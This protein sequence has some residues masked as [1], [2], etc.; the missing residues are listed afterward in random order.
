[1]T[2]SLDFSHA[3]V[4]GLIQGKDITFLT[5]ILS[6]K[7]GRPV[8]ITSEFH[9][10]LVF[11]DP[12]DLGIQ[13][14][15]FF[16]VTPSATDVEN[17]FDD[18]ANVF[19]QGKLLNVQNTY[20][21]D[22][23]PLQVNERCYGYC[24]VFAPESNSNLSQ[25][26]SIPEQQIIKQTA[27]ALLLS[28]RIKR[29][30][31]LTQEQLRDEFLRDVLYNNYDSKASIFE[32]ANYWNWDLQG[33]LVVATITCDPERIKTVREL[34]PNLFNNQ[35]PPNAF[36]NDQLVLILN[37]KSLEKGLLRSA[38]QKFLTEII[39][40]SQSHGLAQVKIGVGSRVASIADLYKSY[41]EAKVAWELG[42][43]F[44]QGSICY[45]E[46]MGFLKFVFTQPAMEL[47]DFSQRILGPL[48]DY[49]LEEESYLLDTLR[50]YIEHK[51]Q[52]TECAKALYIHE[53]TLRN[54]IKKIEQLIGF[55]L[56]RI[57]HLVNLY[58]A[59]Q[60][61]NSGKGE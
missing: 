13:L 34:I 21:F 9:R 29:E 59:L 23:L 53:N 6:Q 35:H 26:L 18:Q 49:D 36:I 43:V 12:S 16:P 48:L 24:I 4:L 15:E 11:Q 25:Q 31:D 37:A 40:R 42:K 7:L 44:C 58:I 47:Q 32:K 51:G 50:L 41:Q 27:L 56:R 1:M 55:D 61:F 19:R 5:R 52:I 57:D 33:G 45:Y 14:Q 8:L 39:T 28:L 2:D 30:Y 10:V 60:I 46:E 22:Y 38:T 17:L 20:V 54:R 3:L